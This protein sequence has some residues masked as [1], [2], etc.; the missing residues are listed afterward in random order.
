MSAK[1]R[2]TMARKTGNWR[3][4]AIS[5]RE[6]GKRAMRLYVGNIPRLANEDALK[7]WF[8]RAG[9]QVESVDLVRERES[10]LSRGFAWVKIADEVFPPKRLRHLKGCTF[11]GRTLVVQK[12][13]RGT[14]RGSNSE[15]E[16]W[17]NPSAA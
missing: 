12:R 9:F 14:D 13:N 8:A 15:L 17:A 5:L 3:L 7:Q 10:G 16:A 4:N 1:L 2:R 11:W 6:R